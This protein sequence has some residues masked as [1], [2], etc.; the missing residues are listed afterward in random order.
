MGSRNHET[1]VEFDLTEL[2]DEFAYPFVLQYEQYKTVRKILDL[3]G[4]KTGFNFLFEHEVR[5]LKQESN[6][7]N[8][9]VK[10]PDGSIK[11][12]RAFSKSV[13]TARVQLFGEKQ[14]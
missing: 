4:G 1:I 2:S 7:V 6:H 11:I 3:F 5:T 12:V 13:A 8:V 9:E 14:K 10:L